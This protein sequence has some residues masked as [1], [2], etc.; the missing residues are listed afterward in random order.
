[1]L[2]FTFAVLVQEVPGIRA[3]AG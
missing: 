1:M 2:C 3:V